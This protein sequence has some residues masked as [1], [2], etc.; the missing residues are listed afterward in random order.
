MSDLVIPQDIY[1]DLL[2]KPWK[3]MP[4]FAL[5]VEVMKRIGT[6]I[7]GDVSAILHS[8]TWKD[9]QESEIQAGDL[10][11]QDAEGDSA[12]HVGIYLG[13]RKVLHSHRVHGVSVIS[14]RAMLAKPSF[15]VRW[16]GVRDRGD[17]LLTPSDCITVV[18]IPNPITSTNRSIYWTTEQDLEAMRPKCATMALVNGVKVPSGTKANLGDCVTF[19]AMPQAA[20]VVTS[21]IL[22]VALQAAGYL[23]SSMLMPG[24]PPVE[25]STP[26]FDLTGLRN[27]SVVGA[28][29]PI[30][31]GEHKVAGNI[32]SA[33]QKFDAE[34]RASLYMLMLLSRGPVEA[35]GGLTTDQD[36]LTGSAIPSSIEI[37]GNPA[38]SYNATV[39][40]RLGNQSQD[41]IDGFREST[42]AVTYDVTL[43]Q[44]TPFVHVCSQAVEKV[45]VQISFPLGLYDLDNGVPT[46]WDVSF[47]YRYRVTGTTT[48][49]SYGT[50]QAIAARRSPTVRQFTIN[51]PSLAVYDIEIER[52]NRPWPETGTDRESKSVLTSINEITRDQLSYPG[53][54]L[55]AVKITATDQLSG[56]LP[57]ITAVVKGRKVWVW[58]GASETSPTFGT[59][60]VWT[61]NPAWCVLDLLVSTEYG[62]GRGSRVTLDQIDLASFDSWADYCDAEPETGAGA[63]AKLDLVIDEVQS[64]WEL[65]QAI[66]RA[67][68]ARAF[69]VG[70]KITILPER[71]VATSAVFS[72]GNMADFSMEWLG[73]ADR[74]NAYEAQYLNAATGYEADW[75]RR[76]DRTAIFTDG[77]PV[78]KR[79]IQATGVTRAIQAARLCQREINRANLIKR[80][81]E[82]TAGVESLHLLPLDVVRVQH[83]ATGRGQGGRAISSTSTTVKVGATVA[84]LPAGAKVYVRTYSSSLGYDIVQ[85]RTVTI[86]SAVEDGSVLTVSSAWTVNPAAGDPVAFGS[87]GTAYPWPKTFIIESVSTKPDLTRRIVAVEY[88]ADV[89]D[90]DPGEIESFTDVMPDPRAMPDDVSNL[91][92][93]VEYLTA[94]DGGC[95]IARVRVDWDTANAWERGDVWWAVAG[96]ESNAYAWTYAGRSDSAAYLDVPKGTSFVVAVAPVSPAGTRRTPDMAQKV[97][98]F[99]GPSGARPDA[100]TALSVGLADMTLTA[101]A[102]PPTDLRDVAWYEFRYGATWDGSVLLRRQESPCLT[103]VSPFASA[104]TVWV[105]TVSPSGI[106]SIDALSATATPVVAT[107]TYTSAATATEHPAWAGTKTNTTVSGSN[108]QLSGSNL[109]GTYV[110]ST[111][112]ATA[113]RSI[114]SV[115]ADTENVSM[116]WDEAGLTWDESTFTWATSYL[117]ANIVT[118]N[119]TWEQAGWTWDGTI[120]SMMTWDGM[121]DL[122]AALTPTVEQNVDGA[123]YVAYVPS[124]K[125]TLSSSVLR[126]TLRRPHSRYNPRMTALVGGLYSF[127]TSGGSVPDFLLFA[128]RI[129]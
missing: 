108:L 50:Y 2:G 9:V 60:P 53:K 49:S 113:V 43:L 54:A 97:Y 94:C 1:D 52:T 116:T 112:S 76:F 8:G 118:P 125:N 35:I 40:T 109:S 123:G 110:T 72:M 105:R 89:Y 34:G 75:Q 42:S 103:I 117:A 6:E 100:P 73:K 87:D 79:S 99:A 81:I 74:V 30:V 44:S 82:W 92:A 122:V 120:S 129:S 124:E 88:D 98:A 95:P 65:V 26:T 126:V 59:V 67:S 15:I 90:D 101:T 68:F 51:L 12:G 128:A 22:G 114:W 36:A 24:E 3:E 111:M 5:A 18:E 71:T 86:T 83:D 17:A 106:Y 84:S 77:N 14:L 91:R 107:S 21:L 66:A 32:I 104:Q 37:D 102:T 78:V 121:P 41:A 69:I 61:Q 45:D 23:I 93:T 48:W 58:D 31:Y 64:G 7:P 85:E 115:T 29:Q 20:G 47:R 28:A 80:R 127:A 25:M 39:W 96:T 33:F 11:A 38:S 62:M 16:S 46:T 10:I 70:N 57:T 56:A 55:L 13:D 27:T 119:P 19:L 63:R 4:C